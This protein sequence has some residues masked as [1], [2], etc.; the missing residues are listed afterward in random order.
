[1]KD[2]MWILGVAL[3]IMGCLGL[4]VCNLFLYGEEASSSTVWHAY[5]GR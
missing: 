1:M 3:A 5:G 4:G 2:W